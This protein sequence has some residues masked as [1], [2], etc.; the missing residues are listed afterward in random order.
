MSGK[1]GLAGVKLV[2]LA[3]AYNLTGV[4]DRGRP[5][6]ALAESIAN[7]GTRC[8]VMAKDPSVDVP[9]EIAPLGD[10]HAPLQDAGGG[11]LVQLAVSE[12]KGLGHP[13]DA[14]GRG[15]VRG[16]FPSSHPGDI[17][18]APVS[19]DRGWLDVHHIS[20]VGAVPLVEGEH[21]RLVRGVLIHGFRTRW[22]RGSPRG[23]RA[24]RGVRLEDDRG[25]GDVTGKNVR[26]DR[27]PPGRDF[28]QLVHLFVV[29]AGHVIELDA[30]ELVLEGSHG[31][32]IRFHLIIVATRVLHDLVNHELR[33]PPHVEA[34]DA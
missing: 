31:L 18:V 6:N 19:L 5:V 34:L 8:G 1:V 17:L 14:P 30:I 21:V 28:G 20:P 32:A 33:I 25:L 15:P 26:R 10:G 24:T 27:N 23:F 16:E 11:A 22:I 2:P 29:P 3:G 9:Q 4:R 12:G 7:E 13:G